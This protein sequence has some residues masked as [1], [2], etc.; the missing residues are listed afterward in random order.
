MQIE[1]VEEKK[2]VLRIVPRDTMGR[3]KEL[4]RAM[5]K[6]DPR[7][8]RLS[9]DDENVAAIASENL[10]EFP[11]VLFEAAVDENGVPCGDELYT[12]EYRLPY[13]LAAQQGYVEEPGYKVVGRGRNN[14]GQVI[15]CYPWITH[16]V[17]VMK[18]DLSVDLERS[19]AEEKRLR[20]LGCVS[21][22]N[23]LELPDTPL[24]RRFLNKQG[25]RARR[26]S[27]SQDA[28]GVRTSARA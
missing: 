11:K 20:E 22:P 6:N 27:K 14:D 7:P 12:A 9:E 23:K 10:A 26:W 16:K 25:A 28:K 5:S 15:V 19:Q 1:R 2:H 13:D 17:G 24:V 8:P 21:D 4:A 18:D 3:T